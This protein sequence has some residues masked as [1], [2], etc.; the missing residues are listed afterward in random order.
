M[1]VTLSGESAVVGGNELGGRAMF[2]KPK[3]KQHM[4]SVEA[5][6]YQFKLN[7]PTGGHSKRLD[8]FLSGPFVIESEEGLMRLDPFFIIFFDDLEREFENIR[9]SK[10]QWRWF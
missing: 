3:S 10:S 1:R 7:F 6:T 8:A 5:E 4:T 2:W 9:D